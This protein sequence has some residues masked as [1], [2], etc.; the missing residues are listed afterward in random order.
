MKHEPLTPMDNSDL[1]H[2]TLNTTTRTENEILRDN[3]FSIVARPNHGQPRW[4]RDGKIYLESD[5]LK[6]CGVSD[7]SG[8]EQF[9]SAVPCCCEEGWTG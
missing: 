9:R 2:P 6:K 7:V 8:G 5:A 4:K 1:P 3:G